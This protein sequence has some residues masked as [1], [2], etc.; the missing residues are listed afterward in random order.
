MSD[1]PI[2]SYEAWKIP[3]VG[4]VSEQISKEREK[5]STNEI[6]KKAYQD[7]YNKGYAESIAQASKDIRSIEE[8]LNRIASESEINISEM[9]GEISKNLIKMSILI[10]KKIIKKEMQ[11]DS[12][13]IRNI[14]QG[15]IT[16]IPLTT[17]K[18]VITM[19]EHDLDLIKNSGFIELLNGYKVITDSAM[20]Q[21]EFSISNNITKLSTSI[22]NQIDIILN[23]LDVD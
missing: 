4:K 20:E 1:T 21:G 11:N 22:D 14:I 6:I 15:A 7:G 23:S 16:Q 8:T 17:E 13:I 19:N 5:I 2:K 10:T 18:L 3:K 9:Y 12:E